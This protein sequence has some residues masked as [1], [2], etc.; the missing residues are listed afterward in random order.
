MDRIETLK[1]MLREDPRNNLA[2]YGLA[3]EYLKAGTLEEAAGE[4]RA[5]LEINENYVAAYF[6]GGQ[7]LEKMG[8]V[9]EAREWYLR[10]IE[11]STRAGDGHARSELQAALEMLPE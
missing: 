3:M 11:A 6:H 9:D 8:R 4:F 10:G 2:R 5:L 7:T 1:S